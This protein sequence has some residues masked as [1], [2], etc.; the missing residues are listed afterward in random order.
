MQ[1]I[2]WNG[3]LFSGMEFDLVEYSIVRFATGRYSRLDRV[4]WF[5]L[6][7]QP[8]LACTAAERLH[9]SWIA[10]YRWMLVLGTRLPREQ[11]QFF[12]TVAIIVDIDDDFQ[13]DTLHL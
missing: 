2:R 6:H 10:P 4:A 7:I 11:Y 3:I 9:L 1:R 8:H 13:P 12:C 5:P